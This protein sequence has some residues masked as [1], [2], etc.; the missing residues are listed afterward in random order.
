MANFSASFYLFALL[1]AF[2]SVKTTITM[3]NADCY[4]ATI[5]GGCPDKH[6]CEITCS[7]CNRGV[8]EV[9]SF[10]KPGGG[11]I[12]YEQC[13]CVMAK[14]APCSPPPPPKC[15]DWPRALSATNVTGNL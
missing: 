2:T 7:T 9:R 15:P 5:G 10:C 8:G 1:F 11:G 4:L 13:V 6:Q 3:V 14:G 12:P